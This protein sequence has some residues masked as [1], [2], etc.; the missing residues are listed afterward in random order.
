ML[1]TKF[2]ALQLFKGNFRDT[3]NSICITILDDSYESSDLTC[4]AT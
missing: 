2:H 4:L 3:L 1:F